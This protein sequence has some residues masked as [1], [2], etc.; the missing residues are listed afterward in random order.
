[1]PNYDFDADGYSDWYSSQPGAGVLISLSNG[2]SFSAASAWYQD[3]QW[4]AGPC[5][6]GDFDGDGRSDL[7][8]VSTSDASLSVLLSDGTKF[9]DPVSWNTDGATLSGTLLTG[10]FNGDG[11][12]DVISARADGTGVD[13]LL[14]TGNG[15]LPAAAWADTEL[16]D[17]S[18]WL[19]GDF[20]GDGKDDI[21]RKIA[22]SYGAE[23]LLSTDGTPILSTNWTTAGVLQ[24]QNWMIGDFN[25]DGKDDLFRVLPYQLEPD[26]FL[27][28]GQG[29]YET[30][31]W[32]DVTGIDFSSARLVDLNG[33][34]LTD[35]AVNDQ[36]SL[37][38]TGHSFVASYSDDQFHPESL[39]IPKVI[40]EGGA[41]I[42]NVDHGD[43][44]ACTIF[45]P[46]T[47]A[48]IAYLPSLPDDGY[49]LEIGDSF[50]PG[51][52]YAVR[53]TS[54]SDPQLSYTTSF[55]VIS[56][57]AADQMLSLLDRFDISYHENTAT[58]LFSDDGWKAGLKSFQD[59][60]DL[61]ASRSAADQHLE[62]EGYGTETANALYLMESVNLMWGYGNPVESTL[63]GRVI[64]NEQF[65]ATDTSQ[66][67]FDLYLNAE[68]ADC[69]DYAAL[70]AYLLTRAGIE[71]R[72]VLTTGHVFNE[73]FVDGK[74][75]T[76]DPTYG[77]AY[78][79]SYAEVLSGAQDIAL[80]DFGRASSALGSD[81]YREITDD[82]YIQKI[83][84]DAAGS[85]SSPQYLS[86][87][88]FYDY[89]ADG[90]IY[91]QALPEGA[92]DQTFAPVPIADGY[93]ATQ[94]DF[95][96]FYYY[97]SNL[98]RFDVSYAGATKADLIG[99]LAGSAPT[100]HGLMY[101]LQLSLARAGT[102][103]E[104]VLL[105][106]QSAISDWDLDAL[107]GSG[108]AYFEAAL[109]GATASTRLVASLASVFGAAGFDVRIIDAHGATFLELVGEKASYVVDP[110]L[111]IVYLG[112]FDEVLGSNQ[113]ETI[114][115][116]NPALFPEQS[117]GD[118]QQAALSQDMKTNLLKFQLGYYADYSSTSFDD[119]LFAQAGGDGQNLQ[120]DSADNTLQ[121]GE[122]NDL[123]SD[124]VG[125]NDTLWG[126]AGNDLIDVTRPLDV[127]G[128]TVVVDGGDGQD[129]IRFNGAGRN[130]DDVW[131]NGG[132][133]DDSIHIV[134]AKTVGINAG[135]G[136]DTIY[137]V[138]N[139]GSS[140]SIDAG[141]GNDT[142]Y[143]SGSGAVTISADE[144]DDTLWIAQSENTI[145]VSL[146]T[147]QDRIVLLPFVSEEG[148]SLGAPVV[149]TDFAVGLAG[150]VLDLSQFLAKSFD[151]DG[152][153]PFASGHLRL[154]QD[155]SSTLVQI[156]L[157]GGGDTFQ[158]VIVLED[159]SA[160]EVSSLNLGGLVEGIEVTGTAA[161]E[162]IVGTSLA[163]VLR[164]LDGD[165]V[166]KGGGGADLMIGGLGDDTYEVDNAGDVVVE[167]AGEGHDTIATSLNTYSLENVPNVE[168]LIFTG[169]GDFTGIGG[170]GDD[171]LQGGDGND[172]LIGNGG[173]DILDGGT[174]FDIVV[175]D[176][177]RR[178]ANVTYGVGEIV[179]D[180]PQGHDRIINVEAIQ[181]ADGLYDVRSD[182]LIAANPRQLLD[183][184]AS[185]DWIVAG[186]SAD[187]VNGGDGNDAIFG[188]FGADILHGNDGD[189]RLEGGEDDDTLYG[190]LGRDTLRGGI[191][192]D[193]LSGGDGDDY[194]NGNAGN[195]VLVGGAGSD[196]LF[197][198][199]GNDQL[200]G[201]DD[202]DYLDGGDGDD[203]L[204]GG[205]GA[206]KL[207]GQAGN[208]Y[209]AGDDGND[210]L[211]G[212][213]GDD[214]LYG[215]DGSDQLFGEDGNDIISGEGDAD[216]ID[217][218]EGDDTLYGGLGADILVG[219]GGADTLYGGDDNDYLNGGLGADVLYGDDGSDQLFGDDG[220][221]YLHGGSRRRLP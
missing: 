198:E 114:I 201:G 120:G 35:I 2:A 156:D 150:D 149:V 140:A 124:H 221:D 32:N 161:P 174:G 171:T 125:G 69:Q 70:N 141:S 196:Q 139:S 67:T 16:T 97:L 47:G 54:V 66:I 136:A 132:D 21:L 188:G 68:I 181:F 28:N 167:L 113:V 53:L 11:K 50:A 116:D 60:G 102:P 179:L 131:A 187:T 80:L 135:G 95:R 30:S 172:T 152:S 63:P 92:L 89:I 15:F 154:L 13:I 169:T 118:A 49:R 18:N 44:Y 183:G 96:D 108:S 88:D 57:D 3:P 215:G 111:G 17:F 217:G 75:W 84:S 106:T 134:D 82:A 159:V 211:N 27:S 65:T 31:H 105:T 43:Q 168:A 29:F 5:Y 77:I 127:P 115:L 42:L 212:G 122:G 128:S 93:N 126:G 64:R 79:A 19:V 34:G 186:D 160:E 204:N 40:T 173:D 123:L 146:G 58:G 182:G 59:L 163:D 6:V 98:S 192:N 55:K 219:R 39:V 101:D 121:G 51:S 12:T 130:L 14:S 195:D 112:R 158:T 213:V 165:D 1:M 142:I 78:G 218:G 103:L 200:Q 205:A 52:F 207:W 85:S 153:N 176:Y 144:G 8:R 83:I 25:G 74:W 164:G 166:I 138:S 23:V 7:L 155:G 184:T 203:T 22:G 210:Y 162:E 191:G 62:F 129:D 206:D 73:A 185:A 99:G 107:G 180:G 133:G 109:A 86:V 157:D 91:R 100:L 147:G 45:D 87:S 41:I 190:E 214:I 151:W 38:S 46:S 24:G 56:Q 177:D 119:W 81:K 178:A 36:F 197:G 209:L 90:F 117:A 148:F 26:V 4:T 76:F 71:N 33:D 20:N 137:L 216:Y 170:S 199:D 9:L 110:R 202:A 193:Y 104:P 145:E 175:L 37:L 189:D 72:I 61:F 208:D 194:L 220:D 10:D 48:V 94:V 143:V